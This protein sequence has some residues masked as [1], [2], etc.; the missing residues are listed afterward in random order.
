M[1]DLKPCPFRIHGEKTKSMTIEG[2]YY[3][4]EY[5]MPCLQGECPCYHADCGD[6]YC[7]RNGAY[8][9]LGKVNR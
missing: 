6:V 4:S 3:Y 7:D 8:M 5:F 9:R 1:N 2:E